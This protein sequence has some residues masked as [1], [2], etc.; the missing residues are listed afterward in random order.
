MANSRLVPALGL[1]ALLLLTGRLSA[2]VDRWTPLGPDGGA[3][4]A[5][6]AP[7]GEE[8]LVFAG[9]E[10]AGV[11]VS[12]D[13]GASWQPVRSGLPTGERIRFVTAGG[14]GG[15]FLFAV[16]G[17][18]VHASEDGGKSW[19]RL[20]LPSQINGSVGMD[21]STGIISFA[22]SPDARSLFLGYRSPGFDNR[23]FR[24]T[25]GGR[26]W[27]AIDL[28]VFPYARLGEIA[29]APSAPATIYAAI[30]FSQGEILRSTDNG[31]TWSVVGNLEEAAFYQEGVELAVHPRDARILFAAYGGTVARST[32]GG[33]TWARLAE[34]DP[35]ASYELRLAAELV[36]D[37]ATPSTIYFAFNR[38]VPGYGG[39]YDGGIIKF[40]GWI[41]RS[42]DGGVNW[43]RAAV[44]DTVSALRIDSVQP[45][46]IYAGVSRIGIL[47]SENGGVAWKKSN[48]G[49]MAAS[50]CAV[51][52]DP[53]TRDLLYISA[54][55]CQQT[56]DDLADNDDLGFLK[57]NTAR[58]WANVSSGLR[59]PVRVLEAYALVPDPQVAGTLYAATGHG[60]FKSVNGG[61][62]WESLPGLTLEAVLSVAIDP[63]DSRILYVTGFSLGYPHCG[64]HCPLEPVY[65]SLKSTDEGVTWTGLLPAELGTGL[66]IVIDP[67][68]PRILYVPDSQGRLLKSTDRGVTWTVLPVKGIG[69]S[70][71]L[72]LVIDPT[73]P[74]TLYAAVY[75]Y[76]D[77]RGSA[78]RS[79]DGGRTWARVSQR[80]QAADIRDLALDR[81]RPTTLYLATSEG[82]FI[83]EDAGAR[84]SPFSKG[85]TS[86]DVYRIQVDLLDSATIYAGTRGDGGLFVLTRSNR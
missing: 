69:Q 4:T 47:R 1:A 67:R 72:R 22:A 35:P 55:V 38:R 31:N 44:S 64:G 54:G 51:T 32:D 83:S 42:T 36:I 74:Q 9:T 5:L 6:A 33:A 77:G 7:S 66:D 10:T 52:P 53:F 8:G 18:E 16:L 3:V 24:S 25:D 68:D 59:N 41:Y 71:L 56:Y 12:R 19:K 85:L 70:V 61:V 50:L 26:S 75:S 76:R 21:L 40:E 29:I 79:T 73:A 80:L 84:W 49:L 43:S 81:E 86:R 20:R 27:K 58:T 28:E 39:W 78:I 82:V 37:P 23:L 46:R 48:R 63:T 60:L 45:R 11:F 14:P 65:G 34:V 17:A 13:G 15:R 2:G 30:L 57:G 62:R